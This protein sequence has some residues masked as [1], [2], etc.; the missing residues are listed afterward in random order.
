[1]FF[2]PSAGFL[3]ANVH[4]GH[5]SLNE[6]FSGIS[7]EDTDVWMPGQAHYIDIYILLGAVVLLQQRH[8]S[9]GFFPVS[10]QEMRL[11]QC[12]MSMARFIWQR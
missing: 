12:F 8:L 9:L 6:I 1:M 7:H 3:R 2:S 5:V 10:T 4:F 11:S